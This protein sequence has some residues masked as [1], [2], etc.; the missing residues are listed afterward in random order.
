MPSTSFESSLSGRQ[1]RAFYV[2]PFGFVGALSDISLTQFDYELFGKTCAPEASSHRDLY[3]DFVRSGSVA[4]D[5]PPNFPASVGD[6]DGLTRPKAS[7][8]QRGEAGADQF[9]SGELSTPP[10]GLEANSV[11]VLRALVAVVVPVDRNHGG[12]VQSTVLAGRG[13]SRAQHRT[14]GYPPSSGHDVF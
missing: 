7:R 11:A 14:F 9:E 1:W 13:H 3:D 6:V 4:N 12:R 2:A 10:S 8:R 5:G